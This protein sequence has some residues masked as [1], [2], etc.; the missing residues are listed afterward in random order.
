MAKNNFVVDY[1][2]MTAGRHEMNFHLDGSF[3]AQFAESEFQNGKI[4]VD[5]TAD[6]SDL[7]IKF[8]DSLIGILLYT[9]PTSATT[10]SFFK[11]KFAYLNLWNLFG[12]KICCEKTWL[13]KRA[14][15]ERLAGVLAFSG[16]EGS[17]GSE[18]FSFTDG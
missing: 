15:R 13:I 12:C 16:S 14:S 1:K 8:N 4:D 9:Y 7:I 3:F 18:A 17:G 10:S 6:I 5:V 11:R 2:T